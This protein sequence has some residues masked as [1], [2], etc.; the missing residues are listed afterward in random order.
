MTNHTGLYIDHVWNSI[1][2]RERVQPFSLVS[3]KISERQVEMQT[4]CTSREIGLNSS[5]HHLSEVGKYE[6]GLY[7]IQHLFY[8][9]LVIVSSITKKTKTLQV[10]P[11][12]IVSV[13][14]DSRSRHIS[15]H[16]AMSSVST[17]YDQT[18]TIAND[19]RIQFIQWRAKSGCSFTL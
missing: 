3:K 1:N 11:I 6:S 16:K 7:V 18:T 10:Q 5:R 2:L 15:R 13:K 8:L 12:L 9:Y 17:F 19:L 14:R 4:A